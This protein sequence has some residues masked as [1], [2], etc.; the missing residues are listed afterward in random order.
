MQ[1]RVALADSAKADADALYARLIDAAPLRGPQ[2]FDQLTASIASLRNMPERCPFVH[3]PH[4]RR[5]GIRC[6]RFGKRLDTY[7]ILYWIDN[8]GR[9]V[10]VLHIRHGAQRDLEEFL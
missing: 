8:P 9:K 4:L 10:W 3:E 1:Y 6:L 2:W 5:M 7:R